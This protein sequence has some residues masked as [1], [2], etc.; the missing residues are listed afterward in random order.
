LGKVVEKVKEK[1][2]GA[3]DKN[4]TDKATTNR[5]KERNGRGDYGTAKTSGKKMLR[6]QHKDIEEME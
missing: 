3:K 1:L 5:C 2:N 6:K 4:T